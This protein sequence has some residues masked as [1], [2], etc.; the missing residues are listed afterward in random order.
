MVPEVTTTASSSLSQETAQ[1]PTRPN[2]LKK[3]LRRPLSRPSALLQTFLLLPRVPLARCRRPSLKKKR[4][5]AVLVS[6]ISSR[7]VIL[8][9]LIMSYYLDPTTQHEAFASTAST[10]TTTG[11]NRPSSTESDTAKS[12][13]AESEIPNSGTAGHSGSALM[14]AVVGALLLACY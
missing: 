12:D 10:L 11:A 2:L 5:G 7:P 6:T 4:L 1:A 14:G 13:T 8:A 9:L 3:P